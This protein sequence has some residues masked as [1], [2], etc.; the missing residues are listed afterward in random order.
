MVARGFWSKS[1]WG[2][3]SAR[4]VQPHPLALTISA[5]KPK[6]CLTLVTY[7]VNLAAIL[8]NANGMV[9]H[10]RAAADVA[11]NEDLN[12]C[13]GFLEVHASLSPVPGL[14]LWLVFIS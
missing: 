10:P 6:S 9:L 1:G 8:H 2:S 4:H 5:S 7:Q 3:V 11:Q 12:G 13:L 14:L